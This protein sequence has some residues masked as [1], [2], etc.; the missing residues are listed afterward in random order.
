LNYAALSQAIQDYVEAGD[1]TF[2]ANIPNFVKAAEQKAYSVVQL[3]VARKSVTG[4]VTAGNKYLTLPSDWLSNYSV[5]VIL[6]DGSYEYMLDKDVNFIREAFPYP[7]VTGMPT[8]YALFDENS[9]ILGP[10][11]DA[12][13]SIE[14]QYASYPRSIV[15]AGTSWL[16]DNFDTVLLYGA[17]VEAN[18]FIKGE[19]DMTTEYQKQFDASLGKL[20]VLGDGKNRRD[21]YRSGQVRTPVM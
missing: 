17:L 4:A 19:V 2:V 6:P 8:H 3:P 7:T 15:D 10:T 11:P 21:A 9:L 14:L 16:G 13:Y 20:K 1:N 12:A 18:M 5:A